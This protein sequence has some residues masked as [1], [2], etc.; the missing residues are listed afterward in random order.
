MN[1]NDVEKLVRM[2]H[3]SLVAS[4]TEHLDSY[5]EQSFSRKYLPFMIRERAIRW[6]FEGE[7]RNRCEFWSCTPFY[8]LPFFTAAM[9]CP[10]DMKRN[11]QLY[12]KFLMRLSPAA[13][14]LPDAAMVQSLKQLLAT[15]SSLAEWLDQ[16]SGR[17][18]ASRPG[19][20]GR[21]ALENLFALSAVIASHLS[22]R[23]A[24]EFYSDR[25]FS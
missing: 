19:R 8:S 10:E 4:L 5:P 17:Q 11:H 21:A 24:A 16:D 2:P 13:A 20:V 23:N 3:G 14:G 12:R 9:A 1:V 18:F 15:E 25:E 6:L 22:P 7:D